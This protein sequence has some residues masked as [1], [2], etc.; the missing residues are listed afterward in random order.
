[1]KKLVLL[2]AMSMMFLSCAD[3][4]KDW[5]IIPVGALLNRT[6]SG[7][8]LGESADTVLNYAIAD[9]ND[10]LED[11]FAFFT[12]ELHRED[13]GT[14]SL[15]AL[16]KLQALHAQGIKVVIGPQTSAEAS[17]LRAYAEQNDMILL[18]PSSVAISL[19]IPGD[20]LYRLPPS[21][22][23]QAKA[24]ARMLIDDNIKQLVTIK[25]EDVWGN[26]LYQAVKSEFEKMGGQAQIVI[27]YNA[28]EH[29]FE[30]YVNTLDQSV[31][32]F[33][34]S[35]E[36]DEVAVYMI[37]MGEGMNILEAA[38]EK[39]NLGKVRW[40]GA[41]AFAEN[42][43]LINNKIAAD[44]AISRGLPCPI[45][46]L[47]PDFELDFWGPIMKKTDAALGRKT[48]IYALC[49]YDALW[50]AALTYERASDNA[51]INSM[52][53][54]LNYQAE[55]YAGPSGYTAFNEAGD[56]A[57]ANY[58]FWSPYKDGDEYSWKTVA[59]YDSESGSL[60]RK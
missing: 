36:N 8:S 57:A 46:G 1:M 43:N 48:D 33:L 40:Y 25:R 41:S 24:M 13:T 19:A 60:F 6:G 44:F 35:Y 16:Q 22:Y 50:L 52:L 59:T 5:K 29:S 37:S 53:E 49:A 23:I 7:N 3:E 42:K 10:Y 55:H 30:D 39:D 17:A 28:K 34:S 45:F 26:D 18:S 32:S 38:A 21:D 51:D 4:G 47:N 2:I 14:D 9:V 54:A 15:R 31:A 20:N 56:R 12:L 27:S 58:D 11:N